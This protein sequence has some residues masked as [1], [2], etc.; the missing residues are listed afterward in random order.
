MVI[1]RRAIPGYKPTPS[2]TLIRIVIVS[3]NARAVS[4][5]LLLRPLSDSYRAIPLTPRTPLAEQSLWSA[6]PSCPLRREHKGTGLRR[7]PSLSLFGTS[8]SCDYSNASLPCFLTISIDGSPGPC[9]HTIQPTHKSAPSERT[10][11]RTYNGSQS[12]IRSFR[13]PK[14]EPSGSWHRN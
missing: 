2:I 12:P 3:A 5:P 9:A 11:H 13:D 14:P 7:G 6:T 10:S 4:I 8:P 1:G